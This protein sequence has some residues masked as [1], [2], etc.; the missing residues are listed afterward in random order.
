MCG[1]G[2]EE[3]QT[4]PPQRADE[5]LAERIGLRCPHWRLEHPQSQVAD[6]LVELLRENA[7]AVMEQKAI[8]MVSRDRFTELLQ[9]PG[10]GRVRCDIGMQHAAGRMFH[11]HKHVEQ[12][13]SCGDHHAEVTGDNRLGMYFR[14]VRGDTRTPSLRTS[15]LAMRS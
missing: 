6:A 13:K 9:R 10:G 8:L 11:Q 3:V 4:L 7:V 14:T 1:E 12:A 5:P 15:S 2:N